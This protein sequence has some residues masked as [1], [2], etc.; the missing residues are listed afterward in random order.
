MCALQFA[1]QSEQSSMNNINVSQE[2]EQRL[3]DLDDRISGYL[4]D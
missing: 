4:D 1:A 3:V 2:I